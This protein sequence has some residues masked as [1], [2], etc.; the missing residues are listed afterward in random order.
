M[1]RRVLVF[2]DIE[3]V[4]RAAAAAVVE[5]VDASPGP[6]RLAL[7]GGETPRMMLEI[8]AGESGLGGGK[9]HF[10]WADERFV[11][12]SDPA[13]NSGNARRLLL[14]RARVPEENIHAVPVD[15]PKPPDAAS[16]YERVLMEHF[17]ISGNRFP[18]FDLVLLGVGSDG[19]T[20]SL[21]PG[22]PVLDE[23]ERLAAAVEAPPG[24]L[25][26]ERITLTLP[27]IN[28]A[29]RVFFLA[30]GRSK[31]AVLRG[32]LEPGSP[33]SRELPASL[34]SPGERLTWFLDRGAGAG[35]DGVRGGG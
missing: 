30:V 18:V 24:V 14:E 3:S 17:G 16:L 9:V 1:N 8:L 19:H 15:V 7:S 28:S 11:P 32:I 6:F 5:L 20:A 29:R 2:E 12:V 34:V 10:F 21:F 4:S 22:D 35:L 25:P 23:R 26:R 13:S 27:V 31:A 33:A